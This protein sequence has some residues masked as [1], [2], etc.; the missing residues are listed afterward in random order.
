MPYLGSV[1]SFSHINYFYTS[2][3]PLWTL[4]PNE[5]LLFVVKKQGWVHSKNQLS[6]ACP[7]WIDGG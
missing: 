6:L 4:N 1:I 7:S 5:A 3:S 2:Y